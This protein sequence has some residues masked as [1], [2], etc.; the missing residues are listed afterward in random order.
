MRPAADCRGLLS[1][2][3][4]MIAAALRSVRCSSGS[5]TPLMAESSQA[6][7]AAGMVSVRKPASAFLARDQFAER[8]C[9]VSLQKQATRQLEGQ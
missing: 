8:R 7:R 5:S 3:R 2:S 9:A 4:F 6:S 1:A